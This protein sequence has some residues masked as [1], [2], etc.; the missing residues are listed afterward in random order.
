MAKT[1]LVR[2]VF[3]R[4]GI[5]LNDVTPQFVR[6]TVRELVGWCN[7]GQRAIAKYVP[8]AGGRVDVIKLAAGSRQ[9]ISRIAASSVIPGD[10]SAPADIHGLFLNEVIRNL[11]ANGATPGPII[12]VTPREALDATN[13]NWHAM[14]ASKS[15]DHFTFDPRTPQ[16]FYVYPPAAESVWVEVSLIAAPKD[17]PLP[18]NDADYEITGT[19]LATLDI[20]D[21]WA[22]DLLNYVMARAWMKDA[23]DAAN[24]A[25]VQ[26]YTQLF[27]NSINAQVTVLTGQ[28]P[29]LK[30]AAMN[31]NIPAAAS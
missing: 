16:T 20:D 17:V 28:N 10:G 15:I 29:N 6:W 4:A 8:I 9:S 19:S 1:T 2:D 23:E 30:W 3:H 18:A 13:R 12:T 27:V 24:A 31:A 14:R 26:M 7:E 11:G 5:L 25:N 22:D 21:R